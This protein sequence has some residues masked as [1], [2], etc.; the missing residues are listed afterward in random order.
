[1]ILQ[2]AY[3]AGACRNRAYAA[4]AGA[5]PPTTIRRSMSTR[6]RT[7]CRSRSARAGI[8]AAMSATPSARRFDHDRDFTFTLASFTAKS[9]SCLRQRRHRLPFQR[10]SARR[11]EFRLS[12]RPTGS[13]TISVDHLR[14][15]DHDDGD[16]VDRNSV[17]RPTPASA[18]AWLEH[19]RQQGLQR[20]WPTA[21]SIS[22]PMSASRPISAPASGWS[23]AN[24][25]ASAARLRD[26]TTTDNADRLPPDRFS[27]R[28]Y[29]STD[30]E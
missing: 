27:I 20:A 3:S 7:M 30:P 15:L 12:A 9:R 21:M 10:L 26:M 18:P 6:R 2:I 13:A 1:M 29:D 11:A 22:A 4:D 23:T 5:R 24:I 17:S 19:R 25:R 16:D 14:R 8:C 28:G